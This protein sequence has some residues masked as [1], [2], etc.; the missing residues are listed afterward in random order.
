MINQTDLKWFLEIAATKHMTRAS[1]RLGISQPALSHWLKN[2]EH[3]LQRSLFLRSRRGMELTSFGEK[4][5]QKSHSLL[6][7]W[8]DFMQE[9]ESD[10]TQL[11][12]RFHFG[13]HES[14]ALFALPKIYQHLSR[15]APG[16]KLSLRHGLSRYMLEEVVSKKLDLALVVNPSPNPELIIRELYRDH[17]KVYALKKKVQPRL[18]LNPAIFQSNELVQK[19]KDLPAERIET[20][21]FEVAAHLAL[22]GEG[23][24]VLPER[25]AQALAPGKLFAVSSFSIIDRHCLV[26]RQRMRETPAGR[27]LIQIIKESL[28]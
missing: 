2:L 27:A 24:V 16:L 12:G 17:I 8:E 22:A 5:Q 10:E 13:L 6:Q 26:Y 15:E 7:G 9:I 19:I 28:N 1:E 20:S 23:S 11:R 21:S 4:L 18:I 3:Q 25:V 14:V